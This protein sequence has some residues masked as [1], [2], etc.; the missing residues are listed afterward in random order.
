MMENF[1]KKVH[2]RLIFAGI[3]CA[4]VLTLIAVSM[5]IGLDDSATAFTLGF[6]I[7]IETVVIFFMGKYLGALKS[8]D[9][10]KKLYIEE[11][12]ERRKHINAQI[13][14]TGI[15]ISI[16]FFAL[17]MLV[18]NYF[19]QTVFFTL[20]AVTLFNVIVKIVLEL[21]YNKKV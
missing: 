18:F 17:A 2:K 15:N 4:I 12:D 8:E 9:K 13:G 14:G 16:L 20:L 19:N 10:L 21:Y 1:Q 3:Y 6:G 11:N 7:G 5:I